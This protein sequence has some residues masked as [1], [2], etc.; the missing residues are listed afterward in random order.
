M[1]MSRRVSRCMTVFVL[2]QNECEIN[3]TAR[4]ILS[5]PSILSFMLLYE[6]WHARLLVRDN[7]R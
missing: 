2:V 6:I 4:K 5:L 3:V 7:A 1:L